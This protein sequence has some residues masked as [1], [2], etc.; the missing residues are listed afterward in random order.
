LTNVMQRYVLIMD[1]LLKILI[2][3][4]SLVLS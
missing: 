4:L 1:T 2:L 3:A